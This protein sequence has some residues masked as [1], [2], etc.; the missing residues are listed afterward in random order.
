MT[1]LQ[2]ERTTVKRMAERGR[3]DIE[4]IYSILDESYVCHV[5][6]VVD[7]QPVVIPTLHARIGDDLPSTAPP[8]AGCSARPSPSRSA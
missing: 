4:T 1:D 7:D 6:I 2:S 8:P 3:Y 5:G